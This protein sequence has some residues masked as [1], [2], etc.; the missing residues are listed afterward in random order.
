MCYSKLTNYKEVF[1]EY[2]ILSKIFGRPTLEKL[3]IIF[4][5]LK[6][7]AQRVPTTLGGGKLGYLG[8]ILEATIYN[9]I[10]GS[11][12]FRRPTDPG[13][14]QPQTTTARPGTRSTE[15]SKPTPLSA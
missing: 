4:K 10:P 9:T 2:K 8:L 12:P 3:V 13:V 1:F 11:A 14:F 15:V 5:Q 7:N 6:H